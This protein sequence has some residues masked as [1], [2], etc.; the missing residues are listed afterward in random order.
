MEV[1]YTQCCSLDVHK[2]TVAA[3][4]RVVMDGKV[5]KEVRTFATTTADLINLSVWLAEKRLISQGI[6]GKGTFHNPEF[7]R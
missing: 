5:V 1:L 4:L 2:E 3:C 7:T 6:T